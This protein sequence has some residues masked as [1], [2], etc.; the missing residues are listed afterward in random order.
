MIYL[1]TKRLILRDYCEDDFNEYYRLKTDSK[2]MYYLQDIQLHTKEEAYEDFHKVLEDMSNF[3]RKFYF[4]HMELKDS[5]EQVGSV[6]YTVINDTPVGK[7]VGAGYF[8]YPKFWGKG[9][10][11]EAF[12]RVLEF[13]F[14]NNNVYRV[15]TGCLAENIGSERVMQKCGLIKEAEHIDHEWH[16]GKMK[17]RLEYRLLKREW[18]HQN[19]SSPKYLS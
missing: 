10:T 2:T 8:I 4:M 1:E 15:S 19:T 17:T 6:G 13:A 7:I 11:T 9:Y 16:D 5:H 3:D 12:R 14:C 18:E